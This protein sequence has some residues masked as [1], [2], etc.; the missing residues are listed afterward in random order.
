MTYI[1]TLSEVEGSVMLSEAN[2]EVETTIFLGKIEI[3]I[4]QIFRGWLWQTLVI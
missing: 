1:V 4:K 3:K 2:G